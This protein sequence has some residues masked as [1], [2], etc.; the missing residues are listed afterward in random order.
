MNCH[1]YFTRCC[2]IVIPLSLTVVEGGAEFEKLTRLHAVKLIP[3]MNCW[4]EEASLAVGEVVGY[5]SFKSASRM[6]GAIVIFLDNVSNNLVERGV[7][8]HDTF[9]S[10]LPLVS[11]PKK[12]T[13]SNAPPFIKNETLTKELPLQSPPKLQAALPLL[14]RTPLS[15][16]W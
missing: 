13:I 16:R 6:N 14:R 4:V 8:I 15:R 3:T 11:P 12:V 10:I 1:G 5:D 7:V 9:M 2:H